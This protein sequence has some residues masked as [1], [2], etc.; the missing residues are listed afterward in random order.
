MRA[1]G[2]FD[3]DISEELTFVSDDDLDDGNEFE[4][5]SEIIFP[6]SGEDTIGDLSSVK[7]ADMGGAYQETEQVRMPKNVGIRPAGPQGAKANVAANGGVRVH[8]KPIVKIDDSSAKA[9]SDEE[10]G[11]ENTGDRVTAGSL[12]IMEK[13][14]IIMA[15]CVILLLIVVGGVFFISKNKSSSVAGSSVVNENGLVYNRELAGAGSELA[16]IDVIGGTGIAAEVDA[17]KA[18]VLAAEEAAKE[19]E[20]VEEEDKDSYDET[21]Y[22]TDV[23]IA[24]ETVSVVKDLKVKLINKKTGKLIANI[25]FELTVTTPNGNTMTWTDSDKDGII[26][27]SDL[28]AG[29]YTLHMSELDEDK[30]KG[31]TLP[32]DTKSEVKAEI[33][34][35]KVNVAD[36]ILNAKDVNEAT[37]DTARDGAGDEGQTLTDTVAWVESSSSVTYT[38]L[39]DNSAVVTP[40]LLSYLDYGNVV[41]ARVTDYNSDAS[42]YSMTL[43][44]ESVTVAA[45]G[46]ADVT[47]TLTGIEES[48]VTA[49]SA[50]T[51]IATV[52]KSGTTLTITGV[53]EGST[54]ITV[55][56][57][58][59]EGDTA[60][61]SRQINVTVTAAATVKGTIAAEKT[62]AGVLKG[63]TGSVAV[64]LTGL[65]ASLVTVTSSNTAVSTATL[66]SDGKTLSITGV[67]AGTATIT[68]ADTADAT[69]TA[70]VTVT[71]YAWTEKLTGT[72]DGKTVQLYIRENDGTYREAVYIDYTANPT[73][74]YADGTY[75]GWQTIGGSTYYY[76]AE[77]KAVTGEQVIKGVRY[78]FDSTGAL[79]TGTGTLGIDISKWNGTINWSKVKASGVSY[80]II[81]VGYRGSTQGGLIDDSNFKTNIEGAIAAGLKVGVYF[82]TQAVNDSEAVYEASMVLDRISG[83][84]ISYP[85]FLDV[86]ASGGRGDKIDAATRTSVCNTFCKTIQNAGYTAGIYAN[87]TWLTS[88]INT[89]QLGSYKI[90]VAQYNS[91]CTYSGSY[92]M[93]QYTDSGTIDGI[94][95][96]VDLNQSYLG[97]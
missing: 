40:F 94:S 30:Y 51:G 6:D 50:D 54:T 62:S 23:T 14:M 26:Y 91:S 76:T 13:A 39:P 27:Y 55:S 35:E 95:G 33:A 18:A 20:T 11:D 72:V 29:T 80:V 38:A 77:G 63:N 45:G 86:E 93:W 1:N 82:V 87:K 24:F 60:I 25:P 58:V 19:Q 43:S 56:Q 96:N 12:G 70:S 2:S 49:V 61:S 57:T 69:V 65:E 90:W 64:T 97:Y 3:N 66:S 17:K 83:Y 48:A 53:A 92:A 85:I 41:T 44:S 59:G 34:Y 88:K 37:E 84:K 22:T 31:Y 79:M 42:L 16:G 46:N 81:R 78:N 4:G 5:E 52:Q 32:S 71:V 68:L 74:Y 75:T 73:F 9:G 36:E 15:A 10:Y 47:L 67:E 21:D 8:K 89:S 28:T 7:D